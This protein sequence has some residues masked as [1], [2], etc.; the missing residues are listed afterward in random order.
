MPSENNHVQPFDDTPDLLFKAPNLPRGDDPSPSPAP[1]TGP[2][3]GRRGIP[4]RIFHPFPP[5]KDL[6]PG[7]LFFGNP[8]A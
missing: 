3:P 5:F 8:A 4:D 6:N 2:V 1:R 7:T